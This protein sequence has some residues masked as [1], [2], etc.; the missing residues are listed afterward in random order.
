MFVTAT[1]PGNQFSYRTCVHN[2]IFGR[3]WIE[4]TGTIPLKNLAT[5]D[6]CTLHYKKS[7]WFEGINYE[8]SGETRDKDGNLR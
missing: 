7:G 5:G 2:I 4:R 3:I 1:L 6:S 8:I